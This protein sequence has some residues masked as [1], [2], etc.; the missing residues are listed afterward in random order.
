MVIGPRPTD[1]QK[2]KEVLVF[3]GIPTSI[4]L[5]EFEWWKGWALGLLLF[6]PIFWYISDSLYYRHVVHLTGPVEL[7]IRTKGC[8]IIAEPRSAN[9]ATLTYWHMMGKGSIELN[10]D[11]L[12]IDAEMS[13]RVLTFR[14][15]VRLGIADT[16]KH[17]FKNVSLKIE[18]D[19]HSMSAPEPS[20][21]AEMVGVKLSSFRVEHEMEASIMA[22]ADTSI[23]GI[24]AESMKFLVSGGKLEIQELENHPIKAEK[25][26]I[27][28]V[29]N[30]ISFQVHSMDV[31]LAMDSASFKTAVLSS[32]DTTSPSADFYK[33]SAGKGTDRATM[34]MTVSS[35]DCASYFLVADHDTMR[36]KDIELSTVMDSS[37]KE[38]R[39]DKQ[40]LFLA[41]GKERLAKLKKWLKANEDD[42]FVIFMNTVAPHAPKGTFRLLSTAAYRSFSLTMFS[43][44]S[45]G[46]LSPTVH[47]IETPILGFDFL[48]P[49]RDLD[50]SLTAAQEL[51]FS[52][53]VF[54]ALNTEV[55]FT[56]IDIPKA[57][58]LWDPKGPDVYAFVLKRGKDQ[59]GKAFEFWDQDLLTMADVF[60]FYVACW[61]TLGVGLVVAALVIYLLWAVGWPNVE[62]MMRKSNTA[63]SA[64][65]RLSHADFSGLWTVVASY[66]YYPKEGVLLRWQKRDLSAAFTSLTIT[67]RQWPHEWMDRVALERIDYCRIPTFAAVP[68]Q[69]TFLFATNPPTG[70]IPQELYTD[71]WDQGL[72]GTWCLRKGGKPLKAG[73]PMQFQVSGFNGDKLEEKSSWSRATMIRT[74]RA[75][76]EIPLLLFKTLLHV[77]P[78]NTFQYFLDMHC[79]PIDME[80]PLK[81]VM[82]SMK[83]ALVNDP[84]PKFGLFAG[85]YDA[86]YGG[87]LE[88][89]RVK[90]VVSTGLDMQTNKDNLFCET[91]SC[92]LPNN[93]ADARKP[94]DPENPDGPKQSKTFNETFINAE[95]KDGQGTGVAKR[96]FIILDFDAEM[97][98]FNETFSMPISADLT[99]NVRIEAQLIKGEGAE[100]EVDLTRTARKDMQWSEFLQIVCERKG[101][102]VDQLILR[103]GMAPAALLMATARFQEKYIGLPKPAEYIGNAPHIFQKIFPGLHYQYGQVVG[104]SWDGSEPEYEGQTFDLWLVSTPINSQH[105]PQALW[106]KAQTQQ[107]VVAHSV[108]FD[109]GNL[110]FT[111]CPNQPYFVQFSKCRLDVRS[112]DPKKHYLKYARSA[113]FVIDRP[114]SMQDLELGYAAFC[115]FNNIPQS[116]VPR[117]IMELSGADVQEREVYLANGYR[118]PIP[119]PPEMALIRTTQDWGEVENLIQNPRSNYICNGSPLTLKFPPRETF[120]K[121]DRCATR[122][123]VSKTYGKV[124]KVHNKRGTLDVKFDHSWRT[125]KGLMQGLFEKVEEDKPSLQQPLLQG[126][127]SPKKKQQK[128]SQVVQ[129]VRTFIDMPTNVFW[130]FDANWQEEV[131]LYYSFMFAIAR[132]GYIQSSLELYG[133]Y[134]LANCS[135][136]LEKLIRWV[137]RALLFM[138][139]ILTLWS[140]ALIVF[141]YMVNHDRVFSHVAPQLSVLDDVNTIFLTDEALQPTPFVERWQLLDLD[142]KIGII[143]LF[144]YLLMVIITTFYCNFLHKVT[145]LGIIFKIL[146]GLIS[147][148]TLVHIFI[149]VL[150]LCVS[151][152]WVIMGAMIEPNLIPLAIAL[153]GIIIMIKINWSNLMTMK[154]HLVGMLDKLM[155]IV[156]HAIVQMFVSGDAEDTAW[157]TE[158]DQVSF[159]GQLVELVRAAETGITK[160][161]ADQLMMD[162]KPRIVLDMDLWSVSMIEKLRASAAFQEC[163]AE[164]SDKVMVTDFFPADIRT[165]AQELANEQANIEGK[166]KYDE[167]SGAALDANINDKVLSKALA[168][169][170]EAFIPKEGQITEAEEIMKKEVSDNLKLRPAT[171]ECL[172]KAFKKALTLSTG[173]E[174]SVI[175]SPF[176]M[177]AMYVDIRTKQLFTHF[178]EHEEGEGDNKKKVSTMMKFLATLQNKDMD[179]SYMAGIASTLTKLVDWVEIGRVARDFVTVTVPRIIITRVVDD[180]LNEHIDKS[181][182]FNLMIKVYGMAYQDGGEYTKK[183]NETKI[184]VDAGLVSEDDA[185][186]PEVKKILCDAVDAQ[187][188]YDGSIAIDGLISAI[189]WMFLPSA[190]EGTSN[191]MDIVDP[192]WL[193]FGA[194]KEILKGAGWSDEE[195]EP[196][197]LAMR[198]K[199]LTE[200]KGLFR[201]RNLDEVNMLVTALADEGLWK[202]VAKSLMFKVKLFGFIAA[203]QGRDGFEKAQKSANGWQWADWNDLKWVNDNVQW[204]DFVEEAWTNNTKKEVKGGGKAVHFLAVFRSDDFLSEVMYDPAGK[205]ETPPEAKVNGYPTD[206]MDLQ[207]Y[208]NSKDGSIWQDM[209]GGKKK[210]RGLWHEAVMGIFGH[211][212]CVP[213]DIDLFSDALKYQTT[214][215]KSQKAFVQADMLKQFLLKDYLPGSLNMCTFHQF[216]TLIN[217]MLKLDLPEEKLKAEV[218]GKC[219]WCKGDENGELRYLS[220]LGAAMKLWMGYGLW[221]EAIADMIKQILPRGPVQNKALQ[222]L[223]DEFKKMDSRETGIL[224]PAQAVVLIHK[225][226]HPGLTCDDL[227]VTIRNNLNLDIPPRQIH[228]YYTLLDVNCDGVMQVDEFIPMLRLLMVDY[229]PHAILENMNLSTWQIVGFVFMVVL[230]LVFVLV[231]ISLVIRTFTS[232]KGVASAI[233]GG[234]NAC[235]LA[236]AK[237][238]SDASSG[239]NDSVSAVKKQLGLMLVDTICFSLGLSKPVIDKFIALAKETEGGLL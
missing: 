202:A 198:W 67:A 98:L 221:C 228:Y 32:Y 185:A 129:P 211:T 191:E 193:W 175:K 178:V 6:V 227:S 152:L 11:K 50:G 156:M 116:P 162:G 27:K 93:S 52:K 74:S 200:E 229:W 174:D 109:S 12:T 238:Q 95:H 65:Y 42:R 24:D 37:M 124:M 87:L 223:P 206:V 194:F 86:V 197:W 171:A 90:I 29:A 57:E 232:G 49:R 97:K 123:N 66:I 44:V 81:L 40:A 75:F 82:S 80:S 133:W 158:D 125:T 111:A 35:P 140:P 237:I 68:G 117:S 169:S 222:V 213:S 131:L 151:V 58:W 107:Q 226:A 147:F 182:A 166:V 46:M 43:L 45:A 181:A 120:E 208:Y 1:K 160:E 189:K 203:D 164:T 210:L 134:R 31:D 113:E 188:W 214:Q 155:D 118:N 130:K 144:S 23:S 79:L 85:A 199:E 119:T 154:N 157:Q 77:L 88:E 207:W 10:G 149:I 216:K 41:D 9:F 224:Q 84:E 100:R 105:V 70:V 76:S 83:L 220:D 209:S 217:D 30:L 236:F 172:I 230:N 145:E 47:R 153:L 18:P 59:N 19:D 26:D 132:E 168:I 60:M 21:I 61:I 102:L 234:F 56:D 165:K 167:H 205:D 235:T 196:T 92:E 22:A 161:L 201:Y 89:Q 215:M 15:I 16:E 195:M 38:L 106:E 146:N 101:R 110:V 126:E 91:Y 187:R 141:G 54:T 8:D 13:A 51:E 94:F 190:R 186:K 20:N 104:L 139:Q 112:Q 69:E 3:P 163:V 225:V 72:W 150:Y 71:E 63:K 143:W 127:E 115:I 179:M 62:L 173:E 64:S 137:L 212:T 36:D 7:D 48:W 183:G 184:F 28:A 33:L 25:V 231:A 239:F 219:G 192:Q 142:G 39:D 218:F 135:R 136:M 121:G 14:C 96:R 103:D 5:N 55:N 53:G 128:E 99:Q 4:R 2:E 17:H 233:Q 204:P 122:D 73:V 159:C 180:Q 108:T 78:E 148:A 34:K 114:V 138:V 177:S 170:S 176:A